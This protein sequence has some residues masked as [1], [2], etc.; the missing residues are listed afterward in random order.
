MRYPA[1]GTRRMITCSVFYLFGFAGFFGGRSRTRTCDPLIKSQLL[2][3]LS[4]AP[5][6][7]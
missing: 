1:T 4:Y 7:N 3:Q 5:Y 6:A 2:Y